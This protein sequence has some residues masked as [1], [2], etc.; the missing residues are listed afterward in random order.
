MKVHYRQ[1][2][3]RDIKKLKKHPIYNEIFELAFTTLP[4][5]TTLWELTNVKIMRGHSNRYRIRIGDYRMGIEVHDSII[6]IVRTLH[7]KDFYR[8]FL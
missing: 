4:G 7:R 8:Y 1:S 5:I 2:F 6:E 3:L